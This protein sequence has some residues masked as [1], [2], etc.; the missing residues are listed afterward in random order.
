[1]KHFEKIVTKM[2]LQ[3]NNSAHV[4]RSIFITVYLPET[5]ASLRAP[6]L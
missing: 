4:Y 2:L 1:M 3:S 6:V 5:D